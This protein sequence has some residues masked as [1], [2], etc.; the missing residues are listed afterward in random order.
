MS[1]SESHFIVE[2]PLPKSLVLTPLIPTTSKSKLDT[3]DS[4]V[5]RNIYW[6]KDTKYAFTLVLWEIKI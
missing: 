1:L 5:R 2:S 6:L 4:F 3:N